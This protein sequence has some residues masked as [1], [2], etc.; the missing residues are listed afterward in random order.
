MNKRQAKKQAKIRAERS[1]RYSSDIYN[2]GAEVQSAVNRINNRIQ[3]AVKHFGS[4]S[5]IVQDMYSKIDA[6]IPI[7]N[8]RYNANGVLQIAK[9]YQLYRDTD[10]HQTIENLDKSDI[11]TYGEIKAEYQK[12]YDRYVESEADVMSIDNFITVVDGLSDVLQWAYNNQDSEEA[13][14]IID[15][16]RQPK[17]TYS[18]FVMVT[19]LYTQ[20]VNNEQ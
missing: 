4:E 2:T 5:K 18:D 8:Q 9:P 7:Q 16:M 11:K 19:D 20:G 3:T 17:N 13:Q 12:S 10:L 15:I 6:L 14:K 1:K